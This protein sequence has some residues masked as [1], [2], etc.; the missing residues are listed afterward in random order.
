MYVMRKMSSPLSVVFRFLA[1]TKYS[2]VTLN[3]VPRFK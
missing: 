2:T 3:N 1:D